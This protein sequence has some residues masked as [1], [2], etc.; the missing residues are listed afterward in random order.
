V[1]REW[2]EF[3]RSSTAV[4]NAF[5]GPQAD[6][7]VAGVES[8][9]KQHGFNGRLHLMQSNGGVL[10]AAHLRRCPLAMLEAGSVAGMLG[11]AHAGSLIAAKLVLGFDMGGT[12]AKA[13]LIEV[14]ALRTAHLRRIDG[15]G[16][17]V[18]LPGVEVAEIGIGGGSIAWIDEVGALKVGPR[19]AGAEPGPACFGAGGAEPTVTDANVV[20]GRI[21]PTR[22]LGGEMKLD[23]DAA[24]RAIQERIARPLGLSEDAAAAGI[25]AIANSRMALALRGV[26]VAA[27]ADPRQVSL[28]AFGGGGPLHAAA[29][30]REIGIARVIVPPHPACFSAVGMLMADV[31]RDC[32]RT[33][34]RA[35]PGGDYEELNDVLEEL[36]RDGI[37]DLQAAGIPGRNAQCSAYLELRYAGQDAALA[38]PVGTAFYVSSED[39][40]EIRASFDQLHQARFGH[41]SPEAPTEIVNVR[42]VATGTQ[43][44]P[45]FASLR[46]R[47]SAAAPKSQTRRAHLDE[48]G[49]IDCPSF[50]REDLLWRDRILGPAVIEEAYS[51]ILVGPGDEAGVDE[52]GFIFMKIKEAKNAQ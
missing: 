35:F 21:N 41:A 29:V 43:R 15:D 42:I 34:V 19:S 50:R 4:L 9:V 49:T 22:Y 16:L 26:A 1:A 7:Y 36:R 23:V 47:D 33:Y 13:S 12:T 6:K 18:Q 8:L 44:K 39:A 30:A 2:G 32:A 10:T 20:L 40:A 48:A 17:P 3:E 28:V 31:R 46:G 52:Q 5:V 51:T 14:G 38:V 24:R 25:V 45:R 27:G 37:R 11:A